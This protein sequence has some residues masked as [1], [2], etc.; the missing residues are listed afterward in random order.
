MAGY[1]RLIILGNL[2]KDAEVK[3]VKD[4]EVATYSVAVNG[5]RDSVEYFDCEQWNP[6]GVVPYLT[7]G[8]QVLAEGEVQTQTWEKDGQKKSK[9]VIRVFKLQLVGGRREKAVEE[10][11]ASDFR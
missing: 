5:Y 1:Q 9:K 2:T 8:A 10:E 6:G 3:A 7:K 4:S 11:F